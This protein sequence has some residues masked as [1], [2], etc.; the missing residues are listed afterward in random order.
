[1]SPKNEATLELNDDFYNYNEDQLV[2]D[3]TEY[4]SD[5]KR[6]KIDEFCWYYNLYIFISLFVPFYIFTIYIFI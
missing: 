2:F 4:Y 5:G 6:A 3:Y 1:M